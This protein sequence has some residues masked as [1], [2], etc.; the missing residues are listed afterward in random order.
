MVFNSFNYS[1]DDSQSHQILV[2]LFAPKLRSLK[3]IISIWFLLT[4][5][6][7]TGFNEAF[8]VAEYSDYI[9]HVYGAIGM[10]RIKVRHYMPV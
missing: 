3:F 10:I 4:L 5:T 7:E 1:P 9:L 8:C 2:D 6:Y